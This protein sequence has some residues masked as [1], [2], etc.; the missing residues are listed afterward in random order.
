MSN[1]NLEDV[2]FDV[3]FDEYDESPP[4]LVTM[5]DT[6]FTDDTSP[7]P[8]P[9]NSSITLLQGKLFVLN[10]NDHLILFLS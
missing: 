3:S 6:G 10:Y 4:P 2:S 7:P 8:S 5:M 1:L 9:F